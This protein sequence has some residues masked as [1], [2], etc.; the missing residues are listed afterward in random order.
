[1][2]VLLVPKILLAGEGEIRFSLNLSLVSSRGIQVDSAELVLGKDEN[3][4]LAQAVMCTDT[5]V[6]TFDSLDAGNYSL[7]IRLFQKE[8]VLAESHSSS[9]LKDGESKEVHGSITIA[10]AYPILRVNW[11]PGLSFD[12]NDFFNFAIDPDSNFLRR[13]PIEHIDSLA[14]AFQDSGLHYYQ[15]YPVHWGLLDTNLIPIVPY[16]SGDY[17][18]PVTTCHTA[19]AFYD[20]YL[21]NGD[22]LSLLGFTNNVN[23]LLDNC[24][25]NYYLHYEFEFRHKSAFL[26]P[27]WISGMAQGLALVAVSQAYN[28]TNEQKYLDGARG[29]FVTMYRNTEDYFCVGVDA[30]DYYWLEEYPC[31]RFCHVFNGMVSGLWGIWCY[32]VISGDEFARVILEAGLKT[33]ADNYYRW[34]Y[35]DRD[36]SY[37]CLHMG[38]DTKYHEKHLVQLR[39][40]GTFFNV[41]EMLDG[42]D[43]FSNRYF[44]AYPSS[45][46]LPSGACESE[47]IVLS[48]LNWDFHMHSDWLNLGRKTDTL[49]LSCTGN[50]SYLEREASISFTESD[51]NELQT[52]PV[53]QEAG[54]GYMV[55]DFDMI[56]LPKD[57]GLLWIEHKLAEDWTVSC[58][59]HWIE[60][61]KVN[62]SVIYIEYEE[63]A[64]TNFRSAR[65]EIL[66][67]DSILHRG[68]K[69]IQDAGSVMF[70]VY[71]DSVCLAADSGSFDI[72]VRSSSL[73]AAT[74]SQDW[75]QLAAVNDTVLSVN[76]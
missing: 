76:Y 61:S 55:L 13:H 17:R 52:V 46:N 39:Y 32:Y 12:G 21:E 37:Y 10:C 29:I 72:L 74:A 65:L 59:N 28:L 16:P 23:W 2:L 19:L 62:D 66:L 15:A 9:H 34:N 58:E 73:W 30:M 48:S 57:S 35:P 6:H 40:F 27:G 31:S 47:I 70:S 71:P 11:N 54:S 50:N 7:S 1:M 49:D 3:S 22:S 33:I 18:N 26:N 68:V 56:Y 25:S 43:C 14:T 60:A 53:V 20:E 4:M 8:N 5:I 67:G 63:N 75:L 45:I 38:T 69:I 41:P 51:T 64:G 44:A 24:D 36:L 42:A